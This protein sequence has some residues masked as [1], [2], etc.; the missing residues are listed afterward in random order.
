LRLPSSAARGAHDGTK[1]KVKI[2][3]DKESADKGAKEFDDEFIFAEGKFTSTASKLTGSNRGRYRF[4]T[5]E[6]EVEWSADKET[7]SADMAGWGGRVAATPR[8]GTST[9][10]ERRTSLFYKLPARRSSAPI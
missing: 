7:S 10:E 3:P 8:P 9:A 6:G 1:W 5:E 4:E 2:T